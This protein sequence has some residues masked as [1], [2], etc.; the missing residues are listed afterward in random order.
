VTTGGKEGDHD[1]LGVRVGR[2]CAGRNIA[3]HFSVP[4]AIKAPAF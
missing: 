3:R 1:E 4:N 2:I